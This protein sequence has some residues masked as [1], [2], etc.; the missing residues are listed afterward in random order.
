MNPNIYFDWGGKSKLGIEIFQ[1]EGV[2]VNVIAFDPNENTTPLDRAGNNKLIASFSSGIGYGEANGL[3]AIGNTKS[4]GNYRVTEFR[5]ALNIPPKLSSGMLEPRDYS[6]LILDRLNLVT[7]RLNRNKITVFPKAIEYFTCDGYNI[8]KIPI[9]GRWIRNDVEST[10]IPWQAYFD[11]RNPRW[12][13]SIFPNSGNSPLMSI[14][15]YV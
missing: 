4:Q 12:M 5:G 1:N 10:E 2:I 15:V 14:K 8:D 6:E 11:I 3:S 13:P 9:N 7:V